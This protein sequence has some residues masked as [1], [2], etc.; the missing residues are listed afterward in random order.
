MERVM[1]CNDTGAGRIDLSNGTREV[2]EILRCISVEPREIASRHIG[3]TLDE[4]ASEQSASQ[5]VESIVCPTMPMR[6]CTDDRR[7]IGDSTTYGD[8]STCVKGCA[9]GTGP[10]VGVGADDVAQIFR[11]RMMRRIRTLDPFVL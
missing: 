8:I 1:F 6:S 3:R 5:F 4:M 7:S 10:K 9:N 2:Q 11:Q